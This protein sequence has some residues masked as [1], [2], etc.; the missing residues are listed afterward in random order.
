M[1]DRQLSHSKDYFY[2]RGQKLSRPSYFRRNHTQK[3]TIIFPTLELLQGRK[4]EKSVQLAFVEYQPSNL[5]YIL[6]VNNCNHASVINT[7]EKPIVQDM[8]DMC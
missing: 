4:M 6:H 2:A 3:T 5:Q 7:F 1:C 8:I